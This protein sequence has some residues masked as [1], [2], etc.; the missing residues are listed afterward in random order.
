MTVSGYIPVYLKTP[1]Y[2]WKAVT[3]VSYFYTD[4]KYEPHATLIPH[5]H[6]SH[7]THFEKCSLFTLTIV[8]FCWSCL[9]LLTSP[10]LSTPLFSI[11]HD[12]TLFSFTFKSLSF[13]IWR[14]LHMLICMYWDNDKFVTCGGALPI[15]CKLTGLMIFYNRLSVLIKYCIFFSFDA[16][17]MLT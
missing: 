14:P 11:K 5:M 12:E 1:E 4:A 2:S 13:W 8:L 7:K 3:F 17:C 10:L 15:S 6:H 9:W 16:H